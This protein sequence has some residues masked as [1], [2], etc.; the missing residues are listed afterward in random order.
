MP[1]FRTLV[2]DGG[3]THAFFSHAVVHELVTSSSDKR[4]DFDLIVGVSAGAVIGAMV[5]Q[6]IMPEMPASKVRGLTKNMFD[7]VQD[8]GPWF[9]SKYSGS[10][11][12]QRLQEIFG[13]ATIGSCRTRLA[14]LVDRLHSTPMLITS[15]EPQFR[16]L[17]LVQVLDATTALPVLFPPVTIRGQQFIDGGTV[18][19]MPVSLALL[20]GLGIAS[21]GDDVCILSVGTRLSCPQEPVP[22]YSD[23]DVGILQLLSAGLPMKILTQG[24]SLGNELATHWL[25]DRYLRIEACVDGSVDDLGLFD[26]CVT[27]ASETLS[28][29][30]EVV[31]R[32]YTG[33]AGSPAELPA[34]PE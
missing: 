30:A 3:G 33:T 24:S 14:V 10:T 26:H 16:D 4:R 34:V 29:M 19:S 13:D 6:G 9:Q 23:D 8:S 28:A 1:P 17:S 7:R 15:W 27:K 20:L 18:T 2:I 12:R 11:K 25:R 31:D 21:G 32:W 5:A 22:R